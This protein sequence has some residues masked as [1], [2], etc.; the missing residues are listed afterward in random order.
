VTSTAWHDHL[1]VDEADAVNAILRAA[2]AADGAPPLSDQ[3]RLRLRPGAPPGRY[4]VARDAEA[5]VGY[6][7]LDLEPHPRRDSGP[8]P[9]EPV[10]WRARA[11]VVVDPARRRRGVGA[12]LVARLADAATEGARAGGGLA[13]GGRATLGVWAH[14]DHPAA[15][16][17]AARFGFERDRVLWQM[18]MSGGNL[19]TPSYPDGITVRT[20]EVGHDEEAWLRVNAAAFAHHPEQGRWSIDDVAAREAEPWFDPAGF[21]LA[22]RGGDLVG[23]HW[24]KIHPA[25]PQE[26]NERHEPGEPRRAG[27][28][29]GEVGEVY[30]VGVRP[31]AAGGGLGRALTLTGVSHLAATGT[32]DIMLYVDDEN[33]AAVRMYEKIGFHKTVADVSYTKTFDGCPVTA[34]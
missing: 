23:F 3:A 16:R 22:E 12:S 31:D 8:P 7:D 24:T 25:E 13:G 10:G 6:A 27:R 28:P 11:E 14:G 32:D 30:V 1:T 34:P 29:R 33:G 18:W 15:A 21:F 5:I 9:T 4:L 19:P 2:Q 20:F 26:R 17:L